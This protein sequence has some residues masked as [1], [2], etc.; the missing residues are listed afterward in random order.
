VGTTSIYCVG[1]TIMVND[2]RLSPP[3]EIKAIGDAAKLDQTLGDAASLAEL[4]A[5]A[6]VYGLQF[7]TAQQAELTVPAFQGS[8]AIRY[9]GPAR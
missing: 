4:K 9:A 3:Y 5:R 8:F 6:K 2:T 1:N 7:R